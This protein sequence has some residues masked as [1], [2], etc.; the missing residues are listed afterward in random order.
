MSYDIWALHQDERW[1]ITIDGWDARREPAVEAVLALVNGYLG[2]RA[3]L[4]EG[5]AVSTPATFLNGVFDAATEQVAQAGATPDYQVIAAPTPELVVAPDWGK[6]LLAADG[7]PLNPQDGELLEPRRTLDMR[8]G[9]LLR[10]WRVRA[11]G[12]TTRLR[13]LRVA[14]LADR[15]LMVQLLEI[16]PRTGRAS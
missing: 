11:G 9:V 2:T 1:L 15:H 8:R 4:E 3:A 7:V 14:S 13:S 16:T 12:K 6:L 10:E 5:S